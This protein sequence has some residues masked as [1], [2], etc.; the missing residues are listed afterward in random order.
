MCYGCAH[1]PT[2]SSKPLRTGPRAQER[3]QSLGCRGQVEQTS[4]EQVLKPA[5]LGVR[6]DVSAR[7]SGKCCPLSVAVSFRPPPGIAVRMSEQGECCAMEA[8]WG[9]KRRRLCGREVEVE[10]GD[11]ARGRFCSSIAVCDWEYLMHLDIALSLLL[12]RSL[13]RLLAPSLPPSR[14]P[15]LPRREPDA[16]ARAPRLLR[17]GRRR[18]LDI[19]CSVRGGRC[20]TE[21]NKC[22]GGRAEN[23][24]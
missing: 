23:G 13:A 22:R 15:S 10:R 11:G 19:P 1:V 4:A 5:R 20:E 6:K 2:L 3:N 17:L 12:A 8:A 7:L 24:I 16:V 21:I 14:P 9:A 18:R